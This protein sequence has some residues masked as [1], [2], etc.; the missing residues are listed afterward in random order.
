MAVPTDEPLV[1]PIA[2]YLEDLDEAEVAAGIWRDEFLALGG[3]LRWAYGTTVALDSQA[4]AYR[5]SS[6]PDIDVLV[7][8]SAEE[9]RAEHVVFS[10]AV[11]TFSDDRLLRL[12][13]L[14]EAVPRVHVILRNSTVLVECA[15]P[16]AEAHTP[17]LQT[18]ITAV[19]HAA[20]RLR[21]QLDTV[22]IAA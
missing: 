17:R 14:Q 9:P 7:S 4:G 10:A 18:A 11:T 22:R 13:W 15:V 5:V 12:K 2:S 19:A 8:C 6:G 16:V 1:D 20:R 3:N 21:A